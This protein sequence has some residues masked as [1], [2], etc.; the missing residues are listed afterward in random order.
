MYCT[1]VTGT[2]PVWVLYKI[3]LYCSVVYWWRS[4]RWWC[5]LPVTVYL[6]TIIITNTMILSWEYLSCLINTQHS[7][8]NSKNNYFII[9]IKSKYSM[10]CR[11]KHYCYCCCYYHSWQLLLH[12]SPSIIC[13]GCL[14]VVVVVNVV[15][16][17]HN[18]IYCLTLHAM[19]SWDN[20]KEKDGLTFYMIYTVALH[21]YY[22]KAGKIDFLRIKSTYVYSALHSRQH[23]TVL[24]MP[25]VQC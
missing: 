4:M 2:P 7:L 10:H 13:H 15:S 14:V 5:V 11:H 19:S 1:A 22:S 17:I 18:T 16:S 9:S 8:Y 24:H 21:Y 6:T 25:Q 3:V 12:A 23:Q 20:E